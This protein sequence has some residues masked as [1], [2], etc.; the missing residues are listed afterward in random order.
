MGLF[1]GQLGITTTAAIGRLFEL[2]NNWE[3]QLLPR[4]GRPFELGKS[5]NTIRQLGITTNYGRE[6]A[7]FLNNNRGNWSI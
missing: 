5:I 6:A 7:A 4:S 3:Q 2:G 1:F